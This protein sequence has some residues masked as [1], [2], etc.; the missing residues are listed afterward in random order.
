MYKL[1]ENKKL[2]GSKR[3]LEKKDFLKGVKWG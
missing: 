2:D 1:R 3:E